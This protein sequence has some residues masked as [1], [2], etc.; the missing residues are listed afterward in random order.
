VLDQIKLA[1]SITLAD[2]NDF[3]KAKLTADR[4]YVSVVGKM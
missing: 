4:R 1:D 2:I 3:V